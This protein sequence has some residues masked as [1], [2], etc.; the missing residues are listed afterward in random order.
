MPK[1]PNNKDPEKPGRTKGKNAGT[2]QS[3]KTRSPVPASRRE[4][5]SVRQASELAPL[6]RRC[7]AT[8]R[9]KN[10]APADAL[11]RPSGPVFS[12]N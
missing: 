10:P 9:M 2:G 11:S 4:P 8:G 5:R 1:K 3:R 7:R 12:L 6:R